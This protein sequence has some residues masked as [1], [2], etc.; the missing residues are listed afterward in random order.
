MVKNYC[1]RFGEIL[2]GKSSFHEGVCSV[3]F[4]RRINVFVQGRPSTNVVPAGVSF[5]GLDKNGNALN[6]AEI[7]VLQ[8][9]IPPFLQSITQQG[10]TVS[11][12]HN[13]WIFMSPIIMY[14]H[15]QS[16]EPPLNFA[17]KLARSFSY[18]TSYPVSEK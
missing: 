17:S 18:L 6:L 16:V 2:N 10:L 13:H 12:L 3:S 9:E 4:K 11:A 7:A 5:E 8:E 14:V 15:I 1:E